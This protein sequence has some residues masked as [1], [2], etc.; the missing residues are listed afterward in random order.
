LD[1]FQ[2]QNL[3]PS[4]PTNESVPCS[5]DTKKS[6]PK[7]EQTSDWLKDARA[8]QFGALVRS[9]RGDLDYKKNLENHLQQEM[10]N[11]MF[12][13]A[14]QA[15]LGVFDSHSQKLPGTVIWLSDGRSD[16]EASLNQAIDE[17]KA[18]GAGI[19]AVVFGAGDLR[20]AHEVGVDAVKVSNPAEIMKAFA[21]AFRRIVQAPR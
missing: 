11:S 14:F 9:V 8:K 16:H 12:D 2:D 15:A 19:E 20:L 6:C 21:N 3:L 1:L 18:M 10:H 7:V 13:L 5:E 17:V 4:R